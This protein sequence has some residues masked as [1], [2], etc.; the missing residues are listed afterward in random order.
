MASFLAKIS[1]ERQ[2]KIEKK[3]KIVSMSSYLNRNKKFQKN[4]K[5]IQKN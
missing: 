1:G 5:K 2:R 3:K 4:S